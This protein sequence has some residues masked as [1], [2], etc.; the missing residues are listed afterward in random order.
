MA[1]RPFNSI[2]GISVGNTSVDVILANGDITTTNI[3]A[4]GIVNF[5]STSNVTLGTISNIH[6]AGG[7]SGQVLTTD[8]AGNLTFADTA[9]SDSAAPMP[10]IIPVGETYF[11]PNN[12]QGLFTVPITVDGTFEIDGILAEVGTA[13]NSLN[14]Q[15]IFDD[16]GELTGNTGFTF[17]QAS[18]NFAVPG[19][20]TVASIATNNY[21]YANGQPLDFGGSPGGSN[22]QIQFNNAGE[23][24]ATANLSFDSATNNLAISGNIV[25]TTGAYYGN[26]SGLT[27]IA[28]ANVTGTVANATTAGTVTTNAQPNITSVGTLTGLVV[29][30]SI[31]PSANISY[32]L[33]NATNAF[34]ELY[35]SGN[36]IRLGSSNI[37]SNGTGITLANPSGGTFT[38]VGTQAANSASIIN[39]TS[40]IVIQ[41]NANINFSVA[42]NSNVVTMTG[43]G[44]SINGTLNVSGNG[45]IGGNLF[46]NGNLVYINVEELAVRDPI[47]TLNSGA[48][49]AF[50]VANTGKDVGTALYY[51]DTQAQT[52]FMGWDTSNSEFSFGSQTTISNEVV[53][54]NTLGNARAQTFKGNVDSANS[55]SANYLISSS[56]CVTISGA[57]I[58]VSGNNAGIFASLVDD[59]NLG[60]VSNIVMGGATESV[61]VQGNLIANVNITATGTVSG[62]LLTGTITTNAQPNITSVGTLGNLSVTGNVSSANLT[63]T[64]TIDAVNIKV[65]DLYS[66]RPAISVT[67][68]TMIDSFP[69]TQFRSAKYTMRAGDGTDYQALEVLLV[70]DDINSIITVYGSLSTSGSDLVLFST[71]ISS[72]N[73]N[74]Y[75]TA[76]APNTNLN[77]MGTY[78]PD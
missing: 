8:G 39:G 48:N 26:G 64:N 70:H 78:V 29:S 42:G 22:T 7:N 28:G 1:L 52:A 24:G 61:T 13:I 50:P 43:S 11:V 14:S 36:T 67:A 32:D 27:N 3:T 77:L 40:N 38:V 31:T 34:R 20:A 59:I 54:F 33:G 16:N 45:V 63:V 37:S 72:G 44:A 17:D 23:F 21:Y 53:A 51:Y 2:A 76:I 15:I 9:S 55:V 25:L 62:N 41:P 35:L 58:A 46:V 47:I 68:N 56:G 69:T 18:G 65:T 6:I 73:V 66:K 74:V 75:A 30:G 49:G 60:L 19:N 12:F 71:D 4:N 57:T 5:N 10:Y